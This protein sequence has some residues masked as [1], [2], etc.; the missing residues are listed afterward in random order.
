MSLV[1][2]VLVCS[3]VYSVYSVWCICV[4]IWVK[5]VPCKADVTFV[6]MQVVFDGDADFQRNGP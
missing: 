1:V 6:W 3:I 5:G 4:C 2:Y